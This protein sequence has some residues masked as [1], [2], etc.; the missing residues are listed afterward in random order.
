MSTNYTPKKV[1]VFQIITDKICAFMEQGLIP[2]KQCWST[3]KSHLAVSHTTGKQYSFLNNLL[4]AMDEGQLSHGEYLT[5]KQA[6]AEG[7]S[8]KPGE[9][10]H[11]ITF[12]TF[13]EKKETQEDGTEKIVKSSRPILKY[14][15][16][17]EVSQ[18]T[19]IKRKYP[20]IEPEIK[21][22]VNPIEAAE[23]VIR[24]YY[25]REGIKLNVCASNKAYFRPSTDEVVCPLMG[26]FENEAEYYSTLFHETTHST[27]IE[28]RLNRFKK[29]DYNPFGS[30]NYSKEELVA[31]LGAAYSLGR[32]GIENDFTVKNSAAYLQNWLEALRNDKH[33]FVCACSRAEEAVKF[34]F[35]NER[36]ERN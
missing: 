32:L 21:D 23:E 22:E 26:Q 18:C 36:P 28:T 19:G 11:F 31:E 4:I 10:G 6:L 34:I 8:V 13:P 35:D 14:Y 3:G 30:E 5:F 29:D 1:D 7:G 17:F 25:D 12:W 16:V 33:L 2:W 24:N 9:K 20:N 27:G 15:Y